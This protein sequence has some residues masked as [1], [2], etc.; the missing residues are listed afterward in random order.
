MTPLRDRL[1]TLI[2]DTL[3]LMAASDTIDAGLMRLVADARAVI[4]EI[5]G[6]AA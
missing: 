1:L 3:A 6:A 4:A 5:D 2:A